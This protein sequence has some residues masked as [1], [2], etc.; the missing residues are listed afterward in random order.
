MKN[1]QYL[2]LTLIALAILSGC[3]STKINASLVEAH[4][5]YDSAQS[6][7]QVTE[8]AAPELKLA[9]DT[10]NKAD[11]AMSNGENDATVDQM[12]YIANQQ[13]AIAQETTKRK[14][15]EQTV[16]NASA[17][18]N[19][20]RLQART[21]E[22]DAAKRQVIMVQATA[23]QQ[24]EELAAAS[25]NARS[26]QALI[27]KQEQQLRELNAKKTNRGV[28]VTLG[29]VLFNSNKSDLKSGGVH[30]VKKLADFLKQYPQ[31]NVL[32]EG[33][34]DSTGSESL[35]QA[36]S[37]RRANSVKAA[38]IDLGITSDRVATRG[39]G[40]EFPVAGNDTAANRQ[41]NRRVE[42]IF[43]DDNGKITPR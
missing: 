14:T 4:R 43:S 33:Y 22:A 12:A 16:T 34:T 8:L 42:V 13:V 23:D 37:E 1:I 41:M 26:D 40:K 9:G 17:N 25:A 24:A 19:E 30:N 3:N 7:H 10:L 6:N 27:A 11:T 18:L 38:L 28:V 39:Y 32:I 29:D 21:S 31:R 2:P 15:A 35:N 20:L 36:L 5:N